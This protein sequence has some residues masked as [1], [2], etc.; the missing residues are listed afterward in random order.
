MTS[1]VR[2]FE[3][4]DEAAIRSIMEASLALDAIPGF[5]A[6]DIER[7]L[8]RIVPDPEGTV[9]AL[10]N[11]RVVGYCTPHHDD[12][13]VDPACRRRGH[14]RRLVRAALDAV[15][16][17]GLDDHLQL[18]VPP[19]LPGSV[20]FAE[21]MGLRYR[22]SLWRFELAAA[23]AVPAARLPGRCRPSGP[24]TRRSTRTSTPGCGSCSP[25]S[26]AI[27]RR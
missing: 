15:R 23:Q 25:R 18:Y 17:R 11:D 8:V 26:R 27:R 24:S 10:E 6:T 12:L 7:G 3:P 16:R 21:A 19:H 14:G 1:S 22:S 4:G 5:T 9:V 2:T 13:T 20:A